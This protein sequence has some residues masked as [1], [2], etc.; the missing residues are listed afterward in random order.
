MIAVLKRWF[1]RDA[2]NA[3]S[4][5]PH[6]LSA[7]RGDYREDLIPTLHAEHQELLALFGALERASKSSDEIACRTALDRFTRLLQQHLLAENRH[8]YGYFA[9]QA[10]PDPKLAQRVEAMSAEMLQIGKTLHRF[11]TTY[12][13]ATWSVALRERLQ[14]DLPTIGSMLSHRIH[15]EEAEL[16]PLYL[17]RAS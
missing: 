6:S 7:A 16:Y 2:S 13:Q 1:G 12:A 4:H 17:P 3:G 14:G 11:I 8:L 9:R 5:R 15:E 10:K